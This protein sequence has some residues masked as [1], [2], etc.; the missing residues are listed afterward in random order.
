MVFWS[1]AEPDRYKWVCSPACTELEQ[2]TLDWSAKL[3][4]L[5]SDFHLANGQG[6]GIILVSVN[7]APITRYSSARFDN[8]QNSASESALTAAIAARERALSILARSNNLDAVEGGQNSEIPD[9]IREQ[10]TSKLVMYGSTQTHS[11][12]AK[13]P[14][15]PFHHGQADSPKAARLLGVHFRACPVNE[16]DLFA[17]R[18]GTLKTAIEEDVRKGLV[19]FFVGTSFGASHS[20]LMSR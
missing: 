3:F 7:F 18:G 11:V 9:A 12:A 2:V 13:V 8:I 4:G 6:G 1:S 10:Y 15:T 20:K 19:P 17:L 5:S 16:H 14:I